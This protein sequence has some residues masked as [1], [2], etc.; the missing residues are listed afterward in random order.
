MKEAAQSIS[1]IKDP[2][3]QRRENSTA[4]VV[5]IGNRSIVARL[6]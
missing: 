2:R 5:E 6:T 3:T 4:Q 1:T